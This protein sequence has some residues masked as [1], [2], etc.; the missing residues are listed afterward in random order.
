MALG[1]LEYLN[2]SGCTGPTAYIKSFCMGMHQQMGMRGSKA[3][4]RYHFSGCVYTVRLFL[5]RI[6]EESSKR[7][8]L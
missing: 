4:G 7:A 3:S 6:P 5:S 8:F 2:G 1:L